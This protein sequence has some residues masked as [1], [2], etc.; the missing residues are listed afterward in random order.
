MTKELK[1]TFEGHS[2]NYF[3][4]VAF[5]P[6]G[7][8]LASAAVSWGDG[9]VRLWDITSG[10]CKATFGPARTHPGLDCSVAFNPDGSLLAVGG[11]NGLTLWD[12]RRILKQSHHHIR[13]VSTDDFDV[14]GQQKAVLKG[15]TDLVTSVVFSSNGHTLA[16]GSKD[17]TILLWDITKTP[18]TGQIAQHSL[19]ST[20]EV[21]FRNGKSKRGQC[22]GFFIG[23]GLV[24][25]DT[26]LRTPPAGCW[27]KLAGSWKPFLKEQLL[28]KGYT[29]SIVFDNDYHEYCVIAIDEQQNLAILEMVDFRYFVK[30][31]SLSDNNIQIGD[32]V[33]VS[34][35]PNMFTQGIISSIITHQDRKFFQIT[36]TVPDGCT[37]SPVLNNK[38]HVI[39][40][41]SNNIR[42]PRYYQH[43]NINFVIPSSYI[44]ELLS[45]V[46]E[47]RIERIL[48]SEGINKQDEKENSSVV[49]L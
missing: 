27:T 2:K 37:G 23:H 34:S 1:N 7:R 29:G 5:S 24:A 49:C 44:R 11:G 12:V 38:G 48:K 4:N 26:H 17:G 46:K 25:S 3:F 43:L 42:N 6:H 39:G 31:L 8:L 15:H 10:E 40:I 45:Q 35:Y 47:A 33:Y 41:T 16:T 9:E 30:P 32:T 22:N 13:K 36:A 21:G 19:S 20:V 14:T 18:T 28:K